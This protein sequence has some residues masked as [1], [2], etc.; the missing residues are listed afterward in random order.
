MELR[1]SDAAASASESVMDTGR[2]NFTGTVIQAGR[3]LGLS[4]GFVAVI[5]L[6]GIGMVALV[7]SGGSTDTW[8][9]WSNAGQAFG[10]LTAV[11]SGLALAALIVTF[12]LQLQ[13]LKAQRIELCQQRELL[14][15]AQTALHR[16]AEAELRTLHTDLTKMAIDDTDLA[17]VWPVL[18]AGISPARNRQYLY[19]NL[20]LQHA[21][22]MFRVSDYTEAEM[23]SNLRYLFRS[24]LFRDFWKASQKVRGGVL[25]PGTAE[26]RFDRIARDVFAESDGE[27]NARILPIAESEERAA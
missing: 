11:L 23:R 20:I 3:I 1:S 22:L 26:Y 5:L 14:S 9:R 16:S 24:P 18:E 4:A 8:N 19:A 17:E 2:H 21:W 7:T 12:W 13:E 6:A 25:V 10:V 15:N 27:S